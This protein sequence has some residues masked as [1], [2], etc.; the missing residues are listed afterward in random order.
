MIQRTFQL[1]PGVGPWREKDLWA[2]GCTTW[3]QFPSEGDPVAL[4]IQGDVAARARIAEARA[5][6]ARRDLAQLGR[7]IPPR[8]HWR[9]YP[10]FSRE[11]VFFDIETDGRERLQPTVVSLFHAE[12]LEVFIQGRNLDAL[13]AALNRWPLW[14]TFNGSVFDVPV[15]KHWLPGLNTP[16]LHIDL[17]F[18]CRRVGLPGGLKSVEDALGIARP[19]HLRGARG[20]DAVLLWRAYQSS[21]DVDVLRYLVEYNLYDAFQLRSV[22]EHGYNLAADRLAWDLEPLRPF[23]RGDILYDVTQLLLAISPTPQDEHLLA[24][25][26]AELG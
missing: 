5:A 9:C 14:V 19:L 8:E 11:A 15:L 16:D 20:Q 26:R 17:R 10:A 1:V 2:R 6:L 24:R 22:L 25:V 23:D 12:G 13:P 21:G 18:L 4:S 3:D 7:M